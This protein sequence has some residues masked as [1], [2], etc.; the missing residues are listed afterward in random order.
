MRTLHIYVF[1]I[2]LCTFTIKKKINKT[3][4]VILVDFQLQYYSWEVSLPDGICWVNRKAS[5]VE[6]PSFSSGGH[7]PSSLLR[8]MFKGT[9]R[10]ISLTQAVKESHDEFWISQLLMLLFR[11]VVSTVNE[12]GWDSDT[13]CVVA[14]L[15]CHIIGQCAK[16]IHHFEN[17]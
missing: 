11:W 5:W 13:C 4:D 2:H 1:K 8:N 7:P 12:F 14:S 3:S 17:K 10:E 15:I 9:V 16:S 6:C